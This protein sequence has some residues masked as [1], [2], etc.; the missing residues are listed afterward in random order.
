VPDEEVFAP[1]PSTLLDLHRRM[2]RVFDPAGILN[3]G[4][5]YAAL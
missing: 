2:K 4:R 5:L 1:L 3:P